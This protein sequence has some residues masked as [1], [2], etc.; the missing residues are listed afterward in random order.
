MLGV[1]PQAYIVGYIES[2]IE[3]YERLQRDLPNQSNEIRGIILEL[4]AILRHIT[5]A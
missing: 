2:R 1:K 4:K 5:G 3:L